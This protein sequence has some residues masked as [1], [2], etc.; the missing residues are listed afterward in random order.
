MNPIIFKDESYN[1]CKEV[2][3]MENEQLERFHE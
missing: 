2:E 1:C 3:E